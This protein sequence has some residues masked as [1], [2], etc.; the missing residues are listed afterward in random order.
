VVWFEYRK[1]L[2]IKIHEKKHVIFWSFSSEIRYVFHMNVI[3]FDCAYYGKL[4]GAV[5]PE[6]ADHLRLPVM[7]GKGGT[8]GRKTCIYLR[9]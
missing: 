6:N 5:S 8:K 4:N 9:A 2:K 1:L 7:S 3:T